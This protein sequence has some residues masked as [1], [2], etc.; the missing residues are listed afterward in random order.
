M[1]CY[2]QGLSYAWGVHVRFAWGVH[3][4][5]TMRMLVV[6]CALWPVFCG[7]CSLRECSLHECACVIAACCVNACMSSSHECSSH[8]CARS[9]RLPT[10]WPK[11]DPE[12]GES[13]EGQDNA[14]ACTDNF[15]NHDA[16]VN[17]IAFPG[18]KVCDSLQ[19][20][21][22]CMTLHAGLCIYYVCFYVLSLSAV[23]RGNEGSVRSRYLT[24]DLSLPICDNY[25]IRVKINPNIPLR[26]T[27]ECL[28]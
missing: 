28:R 25:T 3:V 19:S 14:S 4:R 9:F 27:C 21:W 24:G 15:L 1:A 20:L 23:K 22:T 13:R 11:L 10:Q 5:F 12:A 26:T 16:N 17:K 7:E 6:P 8:D 18:I 2:S